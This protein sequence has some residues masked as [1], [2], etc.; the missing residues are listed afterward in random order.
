MGHGNYLTPQAVKNQ[1]C[2]PRRSMAPL[3]ALVDSTDPAFPQ[4][5]A[6]LQD[7]AKAGV[8]LTE[9]TVTIAVKIG[10][11]KWA[12]ES[13]RRITEPQR[14][15]IVYYVRRGE[16]V[17][18]GTTVNPASRLKVLMPDEI[19]AFEP[20]DRATEQRRHR[21]FST[22]RVAAKSEYF[23][24]DAKLMT[25]ISKLRQ[26]HGDP[27]PTWPSMAT[28]GAGYRQTK[29]RASLPKPVTGETVTAAEA[30]RIVD[31]NRDTIYGWLRRGIIT[32][33]GHDEEGVMLFYL[34]HVR[35][36]IHRHR[37]QMNLRRW[38]DTPDPPV[39]A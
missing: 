16:L 28:L 35:F 22:C 9:E 18:I 4:I 31:M 7:M 12:D 34:D 24:Q 26:L 11:Q 13:A 30:A 15:S 33:A 38:R 20:G 25:H 36:L 32:P 19:L 10:K 2:G 17:K 27:D 8:E 37:T 1:R 21:Q 3:L 39:S 5:A 6:V 29:T 14:R 23:R